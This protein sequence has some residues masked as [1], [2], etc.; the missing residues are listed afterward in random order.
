[1][2]LS[3][4]FSTHFYTILTLFFSWLQFTS[5]IYSIHS[6]K[7]FHSNSPLI[8]FYGS[9]YLTM[10]ILISPPLTSSSTTSI[11]VIGC[12]WVDWTALS[13]S[14][15]TAF[16]QLSGDF[17]TRWDSRAHFLPNL[18]LLNSIEGDRKQHNTTTTT[19]WLKCD[20]GT[21]CGLLF[22]FLIP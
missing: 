21:N 9:L 22:P 12:R 11:E 16:G 8:L 1:M 13:E 14:P 17:P 2:C 15:S 6:L 19:I 5:S 4:I 18:R 7:L 3:C 10:S 20:Q